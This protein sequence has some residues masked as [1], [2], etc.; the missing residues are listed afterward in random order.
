[1]KRE[2]DTKPKYSKEL[3][4][5]LPK[6]DRSVSL[7]SWAYNEQELIEGYLWSAV[8]MLREA[9]EDFEIVVVDDCSTDRTPEIL[10]RLSR[11]IPEVRVISNQ[12]NLN[13]GFS[14]R[15]AVMSAHKEFLFWQTV[16]WSYDITGLRIFLELLKD[17]DIVSGVRRT[18]VNIENAFARAI[19]GI[20]RLFG[21]QHLTR[22]SD[23]IRKAIVSIMNYLIIRLL[24][25][26]PLSDFQNIVFYPTNLIQS[27]NFESRSSFTNAEGLIKSHWMGKS[28]IEVPISFI[29]RKAGKGKG[30]QLKA[31]AASVFD[32]SKLWVKW[33]VLGRRGIIK[34]GSI[35]RLDPREW[36]E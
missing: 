1:M 31:I 27:L 16:D 12:E 18:P 24:F 15:K 7:V 23:T 20:T 5:S 14:M 11:S 22:R 29:P 34:R 26:V 35:R 9:V 25:R 3:F 17:Y 10:S 28:I 13:V 32:I 6:F 8:K 36:D 30:T 19:V 2:A 21:I 33:I 4:D